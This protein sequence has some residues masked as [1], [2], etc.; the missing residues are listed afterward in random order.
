M[1]LSF[2][3][4]FTIFF[5]SFLEAKEN[6]KKALGKQ[7]IGKKNLNDKNPNGYTEGDVIN[8]RLKTTDDYGKKE[9]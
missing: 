3:S 2:L 4:Y 6:R 1:C 8:K 5:F 7:R 9:R